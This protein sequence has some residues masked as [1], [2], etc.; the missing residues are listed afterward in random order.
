MFEHSKWIWENQENNKDEYVEFVAEFYSEIDK[1]SVYLS[2]DGDYVLYVNGK[3]VDSNQYGDFEHYKIYDEIDITEY[4]NEEKNVIKILV[5]HWGEPSQK[6]VP[7]K[8]GVIFE[9]NQNGLI[10]TKSG[11]NV[12]Y[13]KSPVY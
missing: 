3:Y 2:C 7:S 9:V 11:E 10:F 13:R 1:T 4:L 12:L 6:Y 8:A 5:W